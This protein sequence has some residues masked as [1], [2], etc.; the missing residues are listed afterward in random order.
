MNYERGVAMTVESA[1]MAI[2]VH[3]VGN[4]LSERFKKLL[5]PTNKKRYNGMFAI[6]E[7][8]SDFDRFNEW[9][10]RILKRNQFSNRKASISQV[11]PE[12]W[13]TR[14]LEDSLKIRQEFQTLD[15]DHVIAMDE[16]FIRFHESEDSVLAPS[17][18]KRVAAT[19]R[20]HD[21]KSGVMLVVAADLTSSLLLPPFI[22][23][24]AKFGGNLMKEWAHYS[25]S[26]V[27]FNE[28]HWMTQKVAIIFLHWLTLQLPKNSIGK[29]EKASGRS[30]F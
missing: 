3:F 22:I 8:F 17:G 19:A 1:K 20:P 23:A 14:A 9:F 21:A 25:K 5:D 30:L 18:S 28:S 4:L 27:I 16:T 26:A 10:L 2:R 6:F 29:I 15:V 24:T 11:V 13:Y 7:T 12:N